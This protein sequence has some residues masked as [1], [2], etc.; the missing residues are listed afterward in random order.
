L[1]PVR[2]YAINFDEKVA[3][4]L[5]AAEEK[6]ADDIIALD[7]REM[8]GAI[9]DAF[10]ICSGTSER[11]VA[12][13]AHH[14]TKEL[15]RMGQRTNHLEGDNLNVWVLIDFGDIV[16]HVFLDEVRETYRLEDLWHKT[17]QIYPGK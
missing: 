4:I 7:F 6:K 5:N 13:I 8:E 17:K 15:R 14:I 2:R 3:F 11:Q 16:V 10:I 1:I 9:T 12:A